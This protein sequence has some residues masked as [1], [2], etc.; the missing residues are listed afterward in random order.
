MCTHSFPLLEQAHGED[1]VHGSPS[2][3]S[4]ARC[5]FERGVKTASA[6][7]V[8]LLLLAFVAPGSQD[9]C[10]RHLPMVPVMNL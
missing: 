5:A 9:V 6:Y 1:T 7:E 4:S 2:K 3:V 10:D 8:L